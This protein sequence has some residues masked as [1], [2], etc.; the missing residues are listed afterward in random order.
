[1]AVFAQ[2]LLSLSRLQIDRVGCGEY[3]SYFTFCMVVDMGIAGLARVA[4]TE[5]SRT[6]DSGTETSRCSYSVMPS[7]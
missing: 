4:T 3:E 2:A 7:A 6:A 5:P 1:M